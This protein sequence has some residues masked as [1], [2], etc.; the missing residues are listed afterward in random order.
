MTVEMEAAAL[1]AV[2]EF[3][4]VQI[5]QLLYGDDDVSGIEWDP[6]E[7]GRNISARESLFWLSVE[8]CLVME[9][10]SPQQP[11]SGACQ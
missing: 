2:A 5:A 3:R 4:H 1:V 9:D 6:R 11:E 10:E 7:F 8:A